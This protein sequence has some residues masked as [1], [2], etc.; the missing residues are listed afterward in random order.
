MQR[1]SGIQIGIG[2]AVVP[3]APLLTQGEA[4]LAASGNGG[5]HIIHAKRNVMEA[6]ALLLKV[7]LPNRR[8]AIGLNQLNGYAVSG[9]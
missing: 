7:L 1:I 8:S 3:V 2:S 5:I 4:C 9:L 6:G